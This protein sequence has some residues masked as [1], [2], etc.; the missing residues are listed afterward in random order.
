MYAEPKFC[1]RY[2]KSS[3]ALNYYSVLRSYLIRYSVL[4]ESSGFG[5]SLPLPRPVMVEAKTRPRLIL[6][7]TTRSSIQSKESAW[8]V[9]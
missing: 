1:V 7:M 4:I 8:R 2:P 3:C 9:A 5:Y 6:P